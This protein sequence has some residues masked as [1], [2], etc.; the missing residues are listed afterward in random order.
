MCVCAAPHH[1][2]RLA[3]YRARRTDDAVVPHRTLQALPP[4]PQHPPPPL[5]PPLPLP[6]MVLH[7][8]RPARTRTLTTH[9]SVAC[10]HGVGPL[11]PL[12]PRLP[13]PHPPRGRLSKA[14]TLPARQPAVPC[15][16]PRRQLQ[17]A[18]LIAEGAARAAI[19]LLLACS[20]RVLV[21]GEEQRD[22]QD[23]LHPP[24]AGAGHQHSAPSPHA[25]HPPGRTPALL[26]PL[27]HQRH[28]N[29]QGLAGRRLVRDHALL[30]QRVRGGRG[31]DRRA[32]SRHLDGR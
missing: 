5:P 31:E 26:G 3:G 15:V 12:P 30:S 4:P 25:E 22:D 17:G 18:H 20:P 28:R 9:P 27:D 11:L 7:D 14:P 23:P 8:A 24:A 19:S 10:A 13:R 2:R 29:A 6:P 1:R 16:M 32:G 21:G